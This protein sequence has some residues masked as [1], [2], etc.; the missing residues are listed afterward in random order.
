MQ[1][2]G[3]L[4]CRGSMA[5]NTL[6]ALRSLF[7]YHREVGGRRPD[8]RV[9]SVHWGGACSGRCGSGDMAA[10]AGIPQGVCGCGGDG[11]RCEC[12][13]PQA[14]S[15]PPS[16]CRD[17]TINEVAAPQERCRRQVPTN[18]AKSARAHACACCVARSSYLR[19]LV[20]CRRSDACRVG[21]RIASVRQGLQRAW[22]G[23]DVFTALPPPSPRAHPLSRSARSCSAA[24]APVGTVIR[25]PHDTQ[26]RSCNRCA[27]VDA[28]VLACRGVTT[29][30]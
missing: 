28:G 7:C 1:G 10:T 18:A 25:R 15:P 4:W 9:A 29:R 14:A 30:R 26:L 24:I 3:G 20:R 22:E 27:R 13:L 17:L 5:C 16:R 23:R 8:R 2:D 12:G 19:R 11:A 6:P 21:M